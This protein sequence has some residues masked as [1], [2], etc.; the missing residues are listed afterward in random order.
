M[1]LSLNL[2]LSSQTFSQPLSL[3]SL[4]TVWIWQAYWEC[5]SFVAVHGG[6]WNE[7]A[8]GEEGAL[9]EACD[10]PAP[11][12]QAA[13]M[14]YY[15]HTAAGFVAV[16]FAAEECQAPTSGTSA[17]AA[18]S[19]RVQQLAVDE[20]LLPALQAVLQEGTYLGADTCQLEFSSLLSPIAKAI[21]AIDKF[22]TEMLSQV[23]ELL[24]AT[25]SAKAVQVMQ[26]VSEQQQVSLMHVPWALVTHLACACAW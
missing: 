13:T 15:R 2:N 19:A 10:E 22:D 24:L 23:W 7:K 21:A 8:A 14:T 5:V 26:K 4:L 6:R 11:T 16:E 18:G 12:Q 3:Q 20:F 17:H 1:E 9:C 25:K